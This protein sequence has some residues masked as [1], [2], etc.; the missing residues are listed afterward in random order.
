MTVKLGLNR[1]VH[2]T[3]SKD[4]YEV[5]KEFSKILLGKEDVAGFVRI[6][7]SEKLYRMRQVEAESKIPSEA[8]RAKGDG[9]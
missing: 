2:A 9:L 7:I 3:I 1:V 4:T 6:A 8:V 5:V